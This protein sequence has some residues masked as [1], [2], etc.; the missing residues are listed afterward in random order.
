MASHHR[1]SVSVLSFCPTLQPSSLRH[2][3][4]F[5]SGTVKWHY[6]LVYVNYLYTVYIRVFIVKK[7]HLHL[8]EGDFKD[9]L[10]EDLRPPLTP[11]WEVLRRRMDFR[12]K[13]SGRVTSVCH[14]DWEVKVKKK[15]LSNIV[16][17]LEGVIENPSSVLCFTTSMYKIEKI[18]RGIIG[19]CDW[20][21]KIVFNMSVVLVVELL[22]FIDDYWFFPCKYFIMWTC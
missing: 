9:T 7:G 8:R 20:D 13:V 18:E 19:P 10:T 17:Y 16:S 3:L 5:V 11:R 2:R 22:F 15:T 14:L 1:E 12:S 6:G 21:Y 4:L